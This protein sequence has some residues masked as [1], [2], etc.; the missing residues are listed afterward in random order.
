MYIHI[1]TYI[2]TQS[3][4]TGTKVIRRKHIVQPTGFGACSSDFKNGYDDLEV[5]MEYGCVFWVQLAEIMPKWRIASLRNQFG[6]N[7]VG[8]DNALSQSSFSNNCNSPWDRVLVNEVIC[9]QNKSQWVNELQRIP[10]IITRP[11]CL[12]YRTKYATAFGN[13]TA[14]GYL[15]AR[16]IWPLAFALLRCI[17]T[18]QNCRI[19]INL[20]TCHRLVLSPSNQLSV[21]TPS[22]IHQHKN[23]YFLLPYS[24]DVVSTKITSIWSIF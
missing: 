21:F 16:F 2:F 4:W 7:G 15:R 3:F 24:I 11:I 19:E 23:R 13:K 6:R 10:S 20:V 12:I 22:T 9:T 8:F 18:S 1:Y 5:Y 14:S 17:L